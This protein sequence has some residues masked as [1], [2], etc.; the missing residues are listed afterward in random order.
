MKR[1]SE[2]KRTVLSIIGLALMIAGASML[3]WSW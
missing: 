1:M 2:R 3:I